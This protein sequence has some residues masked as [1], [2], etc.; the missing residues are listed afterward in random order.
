[1]LSAARSF[2]SVSK[3]SRNL[4]VRK[5]KRKN[6]L[7]FRRNLSIFVRLAKDLKEQ[8]NRELTKRQRRRSQGVVNG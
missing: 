7:S 8:S 6:L 3:R 2:L 1:V 4:K 5:L